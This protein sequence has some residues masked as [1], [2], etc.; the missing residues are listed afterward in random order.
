MV[1]DLKTMMRFMCFKINFSFQKS[2]KF[3]IF[4]CISLWCLLKNYGVKKYPI[5]REPFQLLPKENEEIVCL[6]LSIFNK[7]NFFTHTS[8][9]NNPE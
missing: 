8:K 5:R 9:E 6:I 3:S 1:H 4:N 2:L 7:I